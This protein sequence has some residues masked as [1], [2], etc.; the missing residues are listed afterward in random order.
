M[1]V[2]DEGERLRFVISGTKDNRKFLVVREAAERRDALDRR[3]K[4]AL[5]ACLHLQY[6]CARIGNMGAILHPISMLG[7][8]DAAP[9]NDNIENANAKSHTVSII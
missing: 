3:S 9:E 2:G 5:P 7:D 6:P 4:S 1:F 8:S